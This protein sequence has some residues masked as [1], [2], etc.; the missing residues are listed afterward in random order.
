ME[1]RHTS[2]RGA[3]AA[4]VEYPLNGLHDDPFADSDGG[5]VLPPPT[6]MGREEG[7]LL[8]EWRR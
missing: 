5:P 2:N 8:R 6:E 3:M 1:S 4:A 7:F